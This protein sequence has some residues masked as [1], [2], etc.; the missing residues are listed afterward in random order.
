M[1][2]IEKVSVADWERVAAEEFAVMSNPAVYPW[3]GAELVITPTLSL[4]E[5]MAYVQSVVESCF[6]EDGRYLPEIMEFANSK[7]MLE[8]Y[9]NLR[10]PQNISKCY[11]LIYGTDIVEFV[12]E[13]INPVQFSDI[14]HAIEEG[15]AYRTDSL[16]EQARIRLDE[17]AK[18]VE[19]LEEQTKFLFDGITADDVQR[20]S[21]AV[22]E[23]GIDEEKLV[24][25][26]IKQK[27]AGKDEK[28][29]EE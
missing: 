25:A 6:S 19:N 5:M 20:V 18:S 2:K 11:S 27:N 8:R 21:D 28:G 24:A 7:N 3:H 10:M 14:Q 15:I 9:T 22:G 17:F 4:E 23:N 1:K 16:A 13:K 12:R 26:Y 29:P